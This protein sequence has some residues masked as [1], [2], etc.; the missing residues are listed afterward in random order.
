MTSSEWVIPSVSPEFSD[1]LLDLPIERCGWCW[2]VPWSGMWMPL[3]STGVC[4]L[5]CGLGE[6]LWLGTELC[7]F[8]WVFSSVGRSL[9]PVAAGNRPIRPP[10]WPELGPW[11][12]GAPVH[13]DVAPGR[14]RV[15]LAAH[16]CLLNLQT[17]PGTCQ[18]CRGH[19]QGLPIKGEE[20]A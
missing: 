5:T 17:I 7:V 20:V 6:C 1:V 10:W 18:R 11:P 8:L 13:P 19:L 15:R 14:C 3:A 16:L 9:I 2:G 4:I 12:P